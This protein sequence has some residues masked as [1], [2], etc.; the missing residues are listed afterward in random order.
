MG[1]KEVSNE[2]LKVR[3]S[4]R[5]YLPFYFMIFI[6]FGTMLYIKFSGRVVN[7]LALK[8]VIFFASLVVV[9]TEIHR[10]GNSYE[11][12]DHS[13]VHKKGYFNIFSSR[14]EFGAIS[15]SDVH[16]NLWHRLFSYGNVEVHLFS[17]DN[18]IDIKNINDPY[19]FVKFLH[20]KMGN[21]RRRNG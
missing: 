12:N 13:I 15:D 4:R 21:F 19:G 5:V 1:K 10:L 17:R 18:R 16:Q 20:N 9:I 6:L 8:L 7:D 14:F 11:I 3:N 2:I